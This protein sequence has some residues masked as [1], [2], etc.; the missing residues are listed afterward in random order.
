MALLLIEYRVPDFRAWKEIFD[1]DPLGR[2]RHRATGH[3]IYADLDRPGEVVLGIEF[4]AAA[5]ARAFRDLPAFREVWDL[6][7]AGRSWVVEPVEAV[8]YS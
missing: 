6:S 8:T 2:Q 4:D 1:R 7:G 3:V 5:D